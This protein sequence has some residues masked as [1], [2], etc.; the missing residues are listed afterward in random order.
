[1]IYLVLAVMAST[2]FGVGL[3]LSEVKRRDRV[4]VAFFN[5]LAGS[6]LAALFWVSPWAEAPMQLSS[7]TLFAG[8]FAGAAWVAGL[9]CMMVS[10]RET[11]ITLTAAISRL[12]VIIPIAACAMLWDEGL[13]VGETAGVGLA[14]IA[15]LLLS[16]RA[17]ERDGRVTRQGLA[18]L[19]LLLVSQGAAQIAMKIYEQYCPRE[20][21]TAFVMVLF[22]TASV[23]TGLWV[24]AGQKKIKQSDLLFGGVIGVPNLLSGSFLALALQHVKGTIVF[25]VTNAGTLLLLAL[26]GGWLWK[27]KLGRRGVAGILLTLAALVLINL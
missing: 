5:Y 13:D 17:A 27:E 18:L 23:L 7:A 14:V 9:L 15:V 25:P 3:K 8:L 11:G 21:V 24:L 10:I 16:T 26:L 4:V 12:S 22:V 1:M 2:G 19:F 20:E 6:I